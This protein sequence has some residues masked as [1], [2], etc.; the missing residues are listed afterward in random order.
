MKLTEDYILSILLF[1]H[2]RGATLGKNLFSAPA[3]DILLE[4][5]AVNFGEGT[6]ARPRRRGSQHICELVSRKIDMGPDMGW[7]TRGIK[8][9]KCRPQVVQ[10]SDKFIP[11]GKPRMFQLTLRANPGRSLTPR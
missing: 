3:W 1:G 7:S 4:L 9:C 2:T 8:Q 11:C 5:C 10:R 6:H